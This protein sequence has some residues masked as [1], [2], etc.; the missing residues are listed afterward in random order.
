MSPL[1]RWEEARES[2]AQMLRNWRHV[3][4]WSGQTAED[5][6]AA[7]PDVL[8]VK[9]YNSV[10][11]G[12]EKARN[13]KTNP[14]T[15]LALGLLNLAIAERNWGTIRDRRLADRV[16]AAEPITDEAGAAWGPT[17]FFAAFMGEI[18]IPQRFLK[19]EATDA[20][21]KG[22]SARLRATFQKERTRRGIAKLVAA[23]D[24][25]M[26]YVEGLSD[27]QETRWQEVLLEGSNY[28]PEELD[29]LRANGDY[30][31]ARILQRWQTRA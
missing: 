23:Y 6:A 29:A 28:S 27:E 11:T 8:P 16:K 9:L 30:I 25:M 24:D 12:L 1:K 3:N 14:Q 21:A 22:L 5:W 7:C 18:P 17:E 31:P 2:F 10:I 13:E 15:F 19:R 20:E 26:E 4:G